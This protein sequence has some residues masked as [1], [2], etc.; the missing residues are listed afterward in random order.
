MTS[1][2]IIATDSDASQ[3]DA[4]VNDSPHSSLFHTWRWLKIAEKY[5]KCT[6]YPLLFKRENEPVGIFPLFYQKRYF[7]DMIFSPPPNTALLFLGPVIRGNPQ[8][9][10]YKNESIRIEFQEMVNLFISKNFKP[11]Y[12]SFA[13]PSGFIDVRPFKWAGY[14]TIS[15]FD[16]TTNL[17]C[18]LDS[19]W[20]SLRRKLR[21]DINRAVRRGIYVEEGGEKEL[22]VLYDLMVR[23]YKEQ[24]KVLKVPKQYLIDIYRSFPENLK[25]FTVKYEGKIVTGSVELLFQDEVISWLGNPKPYTTISP[26]PNDLL[27]WEIIKHISSKGFS[28]YTTLGAA[29]DNRLH[30]YYS[31]KF[32]PE[33]RLRLAAKKTSVVA[34][35]IERGYMNFIKPVS[36]KIRSR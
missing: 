28:F 11:H 34:D 4:I 33:L 1:E 18:G 6:L 30:Q 9:K 7:L 31:A 3:W 8:Q 24:N 27:S 10:S 2:T 16:Y 19:L 36:E 12:A 23:R 13:F 17:Q 5:S 21:T 32:N 20:N 22:E 15:M 29:G 25:I 35:W 14:R 26:S